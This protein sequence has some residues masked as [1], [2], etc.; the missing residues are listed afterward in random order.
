MG[1]TKLARSDNP[2]LVLL[3]R[4]GA[5]AVAVTRRMGNAGIF[6]G[7]TLATAAVPPIKLGLLVKRVDFVGFQSLVVI[8]LTGLFT[9]MVLGYQ[10]YYT[11]ARVGTK[12]FLGPMVALALLRELGPVITALMV[13]ARAGSAICAEIGIMRIDEEIDA[14]ELMGLSPFRYLVVPVLLAAMLCT[15]L[16]TAV[17][18]TIGILGGYVVGVR[19]LGVG[20]GTYFGEMMDYVK[21]ED[22]T[23][24]V[25]K[26]LAFGAIIA[27]ICCWK[28][29]GAGYGA[30]GVSKATTQ[31]VVLSSVLILVAD[32]FLTSMLF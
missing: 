30:E 25:Y 19:L 15:P 29:F 31:A 20:A 1:E 18:N 21:F 2:V 22:V 7:Q 28:G 3:A 17:F 9:G 27:W 24:T 8:L 10:G 12:A 14:L 4:I 26:S 5:P 11:L 23:A 6:L 13:T 32:Y 16:L